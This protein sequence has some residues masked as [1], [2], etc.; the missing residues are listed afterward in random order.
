[1]RFLSFYA[2]LPPPTHQCFRCFSAFGGDLRFGR[3]CKD[4]KGGFGSERVFYLWEK[5][6][7]LFKKNINNDGNFLLFGFPIDKRRC[8][9]DANYQINP[10]NWRNESD[11]GTGLTATRLGGTQG[12]RMWFEPRD[13][14]S[15]PS[16]LYGSNTQ[17]NPI[18]DQTGMNRN[19]ILRI[20]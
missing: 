18:G 13:E 10:R 8:L 9:K 12:W 17:G 20:R 5:G 3:Y 1:M 16:A 4:P 11:F 15:A 7:L 2:F 6:G 14:W 19:V